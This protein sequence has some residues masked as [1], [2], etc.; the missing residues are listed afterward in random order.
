MKNG[1]KI[2]AFILMLIALF[3]CDVAMGQSLQII[4]QTIGSSG[5]WNPLNIGIGNFIVQESVGQMSVTGS[6]SQGALEFRQVFL[7]PIQRYSKVPG[8]VGLSHYI[9][10][11]ML[12]STS[13]PLAYI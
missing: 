13:P 2:V 3:Q 10:C 12:G 1:L 4:R 6:F 9:F 11:R 8:R 5:A 7:Q